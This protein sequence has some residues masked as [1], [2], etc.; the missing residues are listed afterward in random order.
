MPQA[1]EKP[2]QRMA[3]NTDGL[4][5][6]RA[7]KAAGKKKAADRMSFAAADCRTFSGCLILQEVPFRF[8][9]CNIKCITRKEGKKDWKCE[10]SLKKWKLPVSAGLCFQKTASVSMPAGKKRYRKEISDNPQPAA[11]HAGSI[12]K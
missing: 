6:G 2:G 9:E 5:R 10:K 11:G 4:Y 7:G 3:E 12:G 8:A 1:R